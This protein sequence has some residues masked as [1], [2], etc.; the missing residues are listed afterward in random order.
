MSILKKSFLKILSY[1]GIALLF[2]IIGILLGENLRNEQK[3]KS[4]PVVKSEK[5]SMS[6]FIINR[7]NDMNT[8]YSSK[9]LMI[10]NSLI[11]TFIEVINSSGIK[12][13]IK[14]EYSK[15]NDIEL[16][17]RNNTGIIQAIY[18]CEDYSE[19]DCID[20]NNKYVSL[21]VDK[22]DEVYNVEASVIDQASITMRNLDENKP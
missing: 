17:M 1:I 16:Q 18:I 2:L 4:E 13:E 12:N 14:Q 15:I 5:V 21:F 19:K 22:I 20:I 6:T 3:N 7:N 8:S 10:D 11:S 9:D